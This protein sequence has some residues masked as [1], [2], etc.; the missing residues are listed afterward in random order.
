MLPLF[1]KK[2]N[3]WVKE[4]EAEQNRTES[5]FNEIIKKTNDHEKLFSN[6]IKGIRTHMEKIS[7]NV[8][9]GGKASKREGSGGEKVTSPKAIADNLELATF[10]SAGRM[11]VKKRSSR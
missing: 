7:A 3:K 10:T 6:Q 9:S 2:L 1:E 4:F 5:S 8:A 11:K